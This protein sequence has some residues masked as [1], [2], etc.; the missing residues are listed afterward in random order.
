MSKIICLIGQTASGKDTVYRKILECYGDRLIPV[1]PYTTR[2]RRVSEQEGVDYHF[3]TFEQLAQLE[4][5]GKV[6]EKRSYHT[7]QGLWIYF[8]AAFP[9]EGEKDRILITTLEGAWNL[10]A[11]Y[12]EENVRVV[13]LHADGKTRLLRYIER[14]SKQSNP[15]YAEV[16]RRFLADLDDFSEDKLSRFSRLYSINTDRPIEDCMREWDEHYRSFMKH[17]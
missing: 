14:E 3:V 2:P 11:Y 13:Y 4:A 6:V 7:T 5:E 9:L 15:D 1:V 17:S 8:T 10:M 16:C 12:G